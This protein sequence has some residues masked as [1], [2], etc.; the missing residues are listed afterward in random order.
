[1]QHATAIN[2]VSKISFGYSIYLYYRI[3]NLQHLVEGLF[4]CYAENWVKFLIVQEGT[5]RIL[6]SVMRGWNLDLEKT[7]IKKKRFKLM[8]CPL[9]S[10][11]LQQLKCNS[12][13]V[14]NMRK[15]R[16]KDRAANCHFAH[17]S[18]LALVVI[19]FQAGKVYSNLYLNNI[20]YNNNKQSP[21]QKQYVNAC[22]SHSIL[23]DE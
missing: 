6:L 13:I 7:W 4:L 21:L 14:R 19:I 11:Q 10:M 9:Y 5:W 2:C 12:I 3:P 23:S 8:P 22:M 15:K 20:K 17:S 16:V 1:M 18:L